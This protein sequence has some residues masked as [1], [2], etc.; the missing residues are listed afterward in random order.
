MA[1]SGTRAG[2]TSP[3]ANAPV[4]L[5]ALEGNWIR[6]FVRPR[7]D[8]DVEIEPAQRPHDAPVEQRDRL[9]LERDP[10]VRPVADVDNE[11]VVDE[12]EVDLKRAQPLRNR[13]RRQSARGDVEGAVPPVIDRRALPEPNLADDLRPHVQ[14]RTRVGPRLER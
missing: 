1:R 9:R 7:V 10:G 12:V 14:G 5:V 3:F 4:Y 8:L 13:G 2:R 6:H 11:L